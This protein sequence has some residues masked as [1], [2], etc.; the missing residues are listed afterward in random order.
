MSLKSINITN[1]LIFD[2]IFIVAFQLGDYF[3]G[4]FGLAGYLGTGVSLSL[5]FVIT[6][7]LLHFRMTPMGWLFC[8]LFGFGATMIGSWIAG[9][10][11]LSGII[12]SF[13]TGTILYF[14]LRQFT[15]TV[16]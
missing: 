11:A 14:L 3:N 15:K 5:V 2:I 9:T 7:W 6:A 13:I 16:K 10:M 8:V 4:M 1:V 12:V